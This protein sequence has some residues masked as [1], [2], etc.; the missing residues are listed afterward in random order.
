MFECSL[1]SWSTLKSISAL[2]APRAGLVLLL[3]VNVCAQ[4]DWI[5]GGLLKEI[6]FLRLAFFF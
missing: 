2:S 4:F 1:Q 5:D 6:E 3:N